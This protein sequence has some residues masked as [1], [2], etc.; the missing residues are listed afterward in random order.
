VIYSQ[1]LQKDIGLPLMLDAD[2]ITTLATPG[3][4]K[5][6]YDFAMM[7]CLFIGF[8]HSRIYLDG[9]INQP[10]MVFLGA[11]IKFGSCAMCLRWY[12]AE[13]AKIGLIFIVC[14][15]DLILGLYYLKVWLEM[16][17]VLAS[18]TNKGKIQ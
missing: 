9:A 10:L 12:L 11:C 14:I 1:N 3:L 6:F 8:G 5:D 16:G 7:W 17:A 2:G 15:P 13:H 18:G 4:A